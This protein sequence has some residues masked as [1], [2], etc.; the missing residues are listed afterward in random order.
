V[1]NF[2]VPDVLGVMA[3]GAGM[4]ALLVAALAA[5]ACGAG[6]PEAMPA[7]VGLVSLPRSKT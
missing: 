7:E 2:P 4:T 1:R 5:G 3:A 6:S